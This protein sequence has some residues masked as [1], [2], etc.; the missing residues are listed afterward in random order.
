MGHIK[1]YGR[2]NLAQEPWVWHMCFRSTRTFIWFD[3]DLRLLSWSYLKCHSNKK[4]YHLQ[5]DSSLTFL[6]RTVE[7]NISNYCTLSRSWLNPIA[8]TEV[9]WDGDAGRRGTAVGIQSREMLWE[10]GWGQRAPNALP[11]KMSSC[12]LSFHK[13]SSAP[14][15]WQACAHK[16]VK[17]RQRALHTIVLV[18]VINIGLVC[19][20]SSGTVSKNKLTVKG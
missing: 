2:L 5:T 1:W 11:F 8:V 12:T 3:E 20:N 15:I 4:H 16:V 7:K 10:D 6:T 17:K 19:V 9:K 18:Y 14:L 13:L